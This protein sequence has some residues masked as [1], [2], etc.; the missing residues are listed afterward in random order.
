MEVVARELGVAVATL[1]RWRADAMS[2]PARERAWTAAA[3]FEAVL[4]TAAMDEASKNAWCRENGVYPQELEQWRAAATQALAEPED[5]RATPRETKADR[6]R[7]KELERELR[8]KE[9]A[10]A[11]AAALL[12]LSK[13]LEGIFP[14]DK[15]E[16]A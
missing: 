7:I 10:L 15:D 9:K 1:E 14:K 6:R 16:D 13:K 3:R 5:A 12:I 8:R 11:E 4:A 2:M